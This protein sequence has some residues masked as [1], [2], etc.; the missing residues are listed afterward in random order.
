MNAKTKKPSRLTQA[1]LETAKD[2]NEVGIMSDEAFGKIAT[3][4]LGTKR[5]A[6]DRGGAGAAERNQTQGN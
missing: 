6:S 4:H 2:M 1:L 3:R 5:K